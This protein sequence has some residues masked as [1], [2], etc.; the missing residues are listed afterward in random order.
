MGVFQ[1]KRDWAATKRTRAEASKAAAK[2]YNDMLHI[3]REKRVADMKVRREAR[4][5]TTEAKK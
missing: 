1:R 2:S 5:S 4:R 3:Q